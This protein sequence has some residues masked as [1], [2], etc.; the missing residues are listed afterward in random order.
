MTFIVFFFFFN[1]TATTEIYTL[2]LHDALPILHRMNLKRLEGEAIRDAILS[3]SGRLDPRMYGSSVPLHPSQFLEARGL[4][5]ERGPLDGD[6]RRSLYVASRRNFL[7][8]M[9]TAF[10]TPTPFTTIGRRNI[11]NVP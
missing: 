6:G 5:A 11:S 4:R 9:M 10:D 8:M 7:P 1:D 2:S 3:V